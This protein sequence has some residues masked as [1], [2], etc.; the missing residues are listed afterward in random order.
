MSGT[1]GL[2]DATELRRVALFVEGLKDLERST[3]LTIAN[4]YL[5][6]EGEMLCEI[7]HDYT[8]RTVQ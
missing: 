3:G 7:K 4:D 2:V 8:I 6:D 5:W 1:L